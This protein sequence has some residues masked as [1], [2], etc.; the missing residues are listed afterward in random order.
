MATVRAEP[1]VPSRRERR[2]RETRA[3]LENAALRLFAEQGYER[4]TVEEIADAADVA[5]RTFFRYF[6]SKQHVLFGEVAHGVAG[7]L[8][9]A[10]RCRPADE[11]P[12]VA[13][14][15]ALRALALDDPDQARLVLDR[16]R[17]VDRLPELGGT[18][19]L[20][21]QRLHEV[22]AGFVAERTD[23]P[24]L[25]LY[26]QLLAAAATGSVKAALAVFEATGGARSLEDLRDESYRTLTAG[27]SAG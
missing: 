13:V 2:K 3:A 25:D 8:D 12:V 23:R 1:A 22:I 17:L 15:A 4:T 16:L 14:G 10:L 20:L 5:V 18:Y 6:Q 21:F 24:V 19:H 27:L 26:P 9:V 11:P 7:R